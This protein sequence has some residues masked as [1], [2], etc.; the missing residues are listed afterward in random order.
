VS[1]PW[2][3]RYAVI[4]EEWPT[5]GD[6]RACAAEPCSE[7][8]QAAALDQFDAVEFVQRTDYELVPAPVAPRKL[9]FQ[10][11]GRRFHGVVYQLRATPDA[12]ERMLTLRTSE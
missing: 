9:T 10:P 4:L 7:L 8:A 3:G 6:A 2:D 12:V 1:F 11:D 5:S